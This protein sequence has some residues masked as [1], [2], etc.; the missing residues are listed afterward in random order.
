MR[1]K[2]RFLK[3][4]LTISVI[5]LL[6]IAL[7]SGL[8]FSFM[9]DA[10][11]YTLRFPH[12]VTGLLYFAILATIAYSVYFTIKVN[13]I[14]ITRIKKTSKFMTFASAFAAIMMIIFFIY[15]CV[16]SITKANFQAYFFF[17]VMRWLLTIPTCVYFAF[18]A[19]PNKIRRVKITPPEYVKLILSICSVL[20][21]LFGILTTYFSSLTATDIAKISQLFV[22]ASCALFLVFEGRFEIF[23]TGDK[24]YLISA[25]TC[26]ALTLGFPFGI[27]IAKIVGKMSPY[28]AFS[29]PELILSVVI[30]IYAL[31]K[32]F[33]VVL[34][35]RA[36]AE[37]SSRA[38][39]ASKF[40]KKPNEKSGEE[41]TDTAE[42]DK[43]ENNSDE[44]K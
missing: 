20:W 25:F 30:G 31:S 15:E 29:Q 39:H 12:V 41:N 24:A 17:R 44:N 38:S 26:T 34:T 32:M 9:Y 36:V 28:R 1:Q 22:Y 5:C 43:V 42:V 10:P 19:M 27:S 13:S 8:C 40:D 7:M 21:C 6:A 18:Q 35:M 4:S 3:K 2:Y 14:N 16:V 37:N 33:A 11:T 23:G